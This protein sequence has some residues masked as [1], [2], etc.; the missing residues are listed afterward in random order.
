MRSF[1]QWLCCIF[2]L[3]LYIGQTNA[4]QKQTLMIDSFDNRSSKVDEKCSGC[5]RTQDGYDIYYETADVHLSY[6]QINPHDN[7]KVLRIEFDLPPAF[8]WGNWISIRRRFQSSLDIEGYQGLEL[9]L[10]I[11]V[12]S[13]NVFLRITLVDW[14]ERIKQ[15]K[16]SFWIIDPTSPIITDNPLQADNDIYG[17]EMWWFDCEQN[18][19]KDKIQKWK[20]IRIP[21]DSFILSYGDGAKINDYKQNLNN[22]IAY[23]INLL[24]GPGAHPYGVIWVDSLC[25]Y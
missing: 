14:A 16:T 13:S 22:I 17:S 20:K 23:E 19:L 7:N 24:S 21:F 6:I 15:D 1:F 10:R 2:I 8:S 25:T 4:Q 18:L 3:S 9:N 5:V 11:E 12:P